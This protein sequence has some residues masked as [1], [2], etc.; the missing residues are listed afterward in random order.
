MEGERRTD[1]RTYENKIHK[2]RNRNT[3]EYIQT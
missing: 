2:K 3:T 1:E